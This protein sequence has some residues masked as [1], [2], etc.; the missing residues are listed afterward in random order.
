MDNSNN[1]EGMRNGLGTIAQDLH[2]RPTQTLHYCV[3]LTQPPRAK[4]KFGKQE[5]PFELLTPDQQRDV[6]IKIL[7]EV[8]LP[9]CERIDYCFEFTKKLELHC[10]GLLVLTDTYDL[11]NYNLATIRKRVMQHPLIVKTNKGSKHS[12]IT[13]NYIHGCDDLTKWSDY[14]L[15][16]I[17]KTP[18]KIQ[19]I[20]NY[21]NT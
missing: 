5:W 16:D 6:Y 4:F 1:T 20:Y 3:T 15:K 8:Y 12:I 17:N 2:D 18:Y 7:R 9:L 10:H 13:N 11:Y 19:S 21:M 14:L